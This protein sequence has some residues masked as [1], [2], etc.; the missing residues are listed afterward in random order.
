[1]LSSSHLHRPAPDTASRIVHAVIRGGLGP[2]GLSLL[3]NALNALHED[4]GGPSGPR[5]MR[6]LL[7][8]S[9]TSPSRH[10]HSSH[11]DLGR[12]PSLHPGA[13]ASMH[14]RWL[15]GSRPPGSATE[16]SRPRPIRARQERQPGGPFESCAIIL[17]PLCIPCRPEAWPPR[18]TRP[19]SRRPVGYHRLL[20]LKGQLGGEGRP[21]HQA[22]GRPRRAPAPRR[23]H[24]R[25][26]IQGPRGGAGSESSRPS[27]SPRS[28][29]PALTL[30]RSAKLHPGWSPSR[31]RVDI[32]EW[33]AEEPEPRRLHVDP[34]RRGSRP[35]RRPTRG[36]G[37]AG[38]LVPE[39]SHDLLFNSTAASGSDATWWRSTLES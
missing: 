33:A 14:P 31:G 2:V 24:P 38:R 37:R 16:T 23:V 6:R 5:R 20:R 22:G 10:P 21:V 32:E 36:S 30:D 1:M 11:G 9:G 3:L 26:D 39:G 25:R 17:R 15:A 4:H 18:P 12:V 34:G 19:W 28:I 29:L 27:T 8:L 7:A 35:R 13:T